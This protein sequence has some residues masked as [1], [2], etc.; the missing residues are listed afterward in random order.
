MLFSRLCA[1]V[2][3]LA[4]TNAWTGCCVCLPIA[5]A[6]WFVSLAPTILKDGACTCAP[7]PPPPPP[8]ETPPTLVLGTLVLKIVLTLVRP[9]A[10]I[11]IAAAIPP[12]PP[13]A[14]ALFAPT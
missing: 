9:V 14:M 1:V 12:I 5:S 13:C 6:N 3:S 10:I 4:T 11:A 2:T 7:P 8:T